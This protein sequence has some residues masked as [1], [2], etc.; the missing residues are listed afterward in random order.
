MFVEPNKGMPL[1][2][3]FYD[4]NAKINTKIGQN[5]RLYLSF[6]R[7]HDVI[8]SNEGLHNNWGNTSGT[9]RWTHNF[10]SRWFLNTAFIVS[11]YRN[12]LNFIY[13]K[14]EFNWH[15]GLSDLNLKAALS[16]YI[17]PDCE[18]RI[19][20]GAIR[21]AFVPNESDSL[22]TSL[23][24]LQ[25]MEYSAFVLNDWKLLRW[26]GFNYGLHLSAFQPLDSDEKVMVYPEPRVSINVMLNDDASIKAAYSRNVQYIQV[27][28]NNSLNYTSLE[29][30][31]PAVNGLK[32]GIADVVSAGF[33]LDFA[34]QF[35][36]SVELYY[37]KGQDQID[38]IDHAQ[39][40]SNPNVLS[41]VRRGNATAYGVE[42][43][44]SKN[45]GRFA[46]AISYTYSRVTYAILDINDD[47]PPCQIFHTTSAS[48][49]V[50][51]SRHVG[52]QVP[53]GSIRAVIPSLCLWASMNTWA[54][55]SRFTPSATRA[56]RPPTIA[57]TFRAPT[58]RRNTRTASTG[59]RVS[60]CSTP[61]TA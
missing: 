42:F 35:S 48:T 26:L 40:I 52:A 4:L 5:D 6:Y 45:V 2:P 13:K 9:L 56:A 43:N 19:G 12:D 39:L 37:K 10:G 60:A 24:H 30:W 58:R 33:F 38:F 55:P 25:A 11:D 57:S 16:Y 53:R 36:T 22:Q 59:A 20:A 7:G 32:P 51:S 46:G 27:L 14:H 3:T 31:F 28:Q 44:L 18:L 8:D 41:Q 29:T 21:H 15:T 23:P 34:E 50:T 49:A 47:N 1:V 61:T 54:R 17:A